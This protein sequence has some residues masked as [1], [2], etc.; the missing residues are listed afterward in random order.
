MY[1]RA[2]AGSKKALRQDYILT[3]SMIN[4]LGNLYRDQ[5]KLD[6]AE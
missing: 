6:E 3:L 4:N 5:G 2:L 1:M